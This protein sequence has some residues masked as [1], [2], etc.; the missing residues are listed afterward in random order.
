MFV[1]EANTNVAKSTSPSSDG[2]NGTNIEKTAS[3]SS[4]VDGIRIGGNGSSNGSNGGSNDTNVAKSTSTSSGGEMNAKSTSSSDGSNHT[5]IEM[6]A[7]SPDIEHV[8]KE[9]DQALERAIEAEER[10]KQAEEMLKQA[11]EMLKKVTKER[12][13]ALRSLGIVWN[14]DP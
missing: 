6:T 10:A 2:S 12:D 13:D 8:M 7:K 11:E 9:R 5:N 3:L 14:A 4:Q 1:A